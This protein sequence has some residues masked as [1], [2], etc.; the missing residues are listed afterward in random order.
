MNNK[1]EVTLMKKIVALIMAIMMVCSL[2]PA[3]AE[4]YTTDFDVPATGE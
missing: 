2:V 1:K 4:A 3:M